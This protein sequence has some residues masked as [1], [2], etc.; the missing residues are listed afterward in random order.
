MKNETAMK[1]MFCKGAMSSNKSVAQTLFTRN[2]ALTISC[3][4]NFPDSLS[5]VEDWIRFS[6]VC[7]LLGF[8]WVGDADFDFNFSA[9]LFSEKLCF[10]DLDEDNIKAECF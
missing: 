3:T 10:C 8:L 4:P 7:F 5:L 1:F 6:S 9:V 2:T